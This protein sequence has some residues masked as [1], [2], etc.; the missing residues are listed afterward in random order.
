[1]NKTL[2]VKLVGTIL[3]AHSASLYATD[4]YVSPDGVEIWPYCIDQ[5]N[6]CEASNTSKDFLNA[7]AGDTVYFLDGIYPG[8]TT[9]YQ[10]YQR[11]PAWF[12]NNSGTADNPI[13]FKALNRRQAILEGLG[14]SIGGG[15]AA[16]HIVPVIGCEYNTGKSHAVWD[17]FVLRAVA[18]DGVTPIMAKASMYKCDNYTIN[19]NE[20]IGVE[21]SMGGQ[22]N[23]DGVRFEGSDYITITNNSIHGFNETS[24]G[25]NTS[26]IKT[27]NSYYAKIHNN[28]F[29]DNHVHLY[30]KGSGNGYFD[31]GYNYFLDGLKG[32]LNPTNAGDEPEHIYHNNLFV[33]IRENITDAGSSTPG[34]TA[35]GVVI[36]NNTF[37]NVGSTGWAWFARQANVSEGHENAIYNNVFYTDNSSLRAI[38]STSSGG[39]KLKQADHNL[40]ATSLFI[41]LPVWGSGSLYYSLP[42]WQSSGVLSANFDAGCG[43]N[44]NPGCG[45]I[46][47]DPLF[48]NRSGMFSQISD[49]ELSESSPG[50][51]AGRD[52]V[53]DMGADIRLVGVRGDISVPNPFSFDDKTNAELN[54][55]YS[56]SITVSGIDSPLQ[57]TVSDGEYRIGSGAWMTAESTVNNGDVVSVRRHSSAT[58]GSTVSATVTIG[59][60]SD[61]FSITTKAATEIS[62]PVAINFQPANANIP[63]GYLV[64]SGLTYGDRGNGYRYGW[65]SNLSSGA[66]DRNNALN[67][68]DQRFDTLLHMWDASWAIALPSGQYDVRLVM[69]DP[70]Y[71]DCD[72][73]VSLEGVTAID[74]PTSSSNRF[75]E[76]DLSVT[77]TD[78]MLTLENLSSGAVNK[79][80][81]IEIRQDTG[82]TD[83]SPNQF[84]FSDKT[85]AELNTS[86]SASISVSG[87]NAASPISVSSGEYRI[88]SGAWMT[89]A[90]TVS[91]G[92][93]VEVRRSA[94]SSYSTTVFSIVTIG[95]VSDTFS[96]TTKAEPIDT[97]PNQFGFADKTN[98][99]LNTRYSASITVGGIN[100]AS[101]ITVSGGEYRIGSGAWM[102]TASSV[103][104][105]DSVSIRRNASA[106]YSSAVSATLTIGGVSDVFSI[107]T[108]AEPTTGGT[109][110]MVS[111]APGSTLS[112]NVVTFEWQDTG[113]LEYY[114]FVGSGS[115]Q[116]NIYIGSQGASTSATI[117]GIP[118]DGSMINAKLWTRHASGWTNKVYTYTAATTGGSGGS[119][120]MPN[121][122]TFADKSNAE[123]NTRY[124]SNITVSGIDAATSIN[125]SS[126]GEYRMGSG[127]WTTASGT[128]NNGDVVT[129]RLTSSAAYSTTVSTTV[130][131]GGVQDV[132]K[133]VTKGA[134][135]VSGAQIQSPSQGSTLNATET[136][137]WNN[138][139]A[140][141]YSF[142]ISSSQFGTGD[143]YYSGLLSSNV[144]SHMATGIPTTG[145]QVWVILNSYSAGIGWQTERYPYTTVSQ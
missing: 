46:A 20:I 134:G 143:I 78:G 70:S 121:Q 135:S 73:A 16:D 94:S 30:I 91:N 61:T 18:S 1:M 90:S 63:D 59:G 85:N 87:I 89:V 139:G 5:S 12:P 116:T 140:T 124:S 13:V 79:V 52:G 117:V 71:T 26:A 83:T 21:H 144:T 128:V 3:L 37:Y 66:R 109:S 138:V 99:E 108:K 57:I 81:F 137:T 126:G 36:K 98:A 113:A 93:I 141:N 125:V 130:T 107:T 95:G 24:G 80:A 54:T 41:A 29:Y 82:S 50:K 103:S 10:T 22:V 104:N 60:V 129:V 76:S 35:D 6:P 45:S 74:Q 102:T 132:Y 33:N 142:A 58:N 92:D 31:V 67:A 40:Y 55:S 123:L 23:W 119:D 97:T 56:A 38:T 84:N 105:G 65:T 100:T 69:G 68:P 145:Q 7:Q 115:S 75:V 131:I 47:A 86:Y 4:Y 48:V 32:V 9:K 39:T 120:I 127:A 77:V 114:L 17:G 122:F 43:S 62:L 49:F 111:P 88:G 133:V 14:H 110:E 42:T 8:L 15:D 11:T 53:V 34:Y 101:P 27:Y 72:C 51:N 64:D 96:I 19:D 136:F 118:T 25:H 112:S 28:N 44:N 106:S 2:F